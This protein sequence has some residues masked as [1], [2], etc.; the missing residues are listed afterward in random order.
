MCP[1]DQ[2]KSPKRRNES[3]L[4]LLAIGTILIVGAAAVSFVL[5]ERSD[6]SHMYG[7]P[8][9]S[10]RLDTPYIPSH[11]TIVQKMVEMADL[12]EDDV[13]YDLG[14]GDGRILIAAAKQSGCRD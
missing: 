10:Q 13:V 9:P 3:R 8:I 1:N 14:C 2:A 7:L 6:V 11:P 5:F 12:T 4:L